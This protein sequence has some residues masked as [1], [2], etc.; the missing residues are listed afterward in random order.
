MIESDIDLF[1]IVKY[2]INDLHTIPLEIDQQTLKKLVD[3]QAI[4]QNLFSLY[5]TN[6]KHIFPLNTL[7][8]GKLNILLGIELYTGRN[9]NVIIA[10]LADKI[11][12]ISELIKEIGKLKK[13]KDAVESNNKG[14]E[15]IHT[16]V[17]K[18]GLEGLSKLEKL[19]EELE[20][21]DLKVKTAIV[22]LSTNKEI[23]E[24]T[25]MSSEELKELLESL[26]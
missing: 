7:T 12:K 14:D 9:K 26:F 6:I 23:L 4:S 17:A 5:T 19:L 3:A 16:L 1:F 22:E 2:Y 25:G 15:N 8:K 13:V 24:Q 20:E 10:L 21:L 18:E 11:P